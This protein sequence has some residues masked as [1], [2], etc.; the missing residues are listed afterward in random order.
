M[1]KEAM[2]EG[3]DVMTPDDFVRVCTDNGLLNSSAAK[4]RLQSEVG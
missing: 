2:T 3:S 1:H 4:T